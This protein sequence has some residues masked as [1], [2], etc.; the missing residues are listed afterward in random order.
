MRS[1]RSTINLVGLVS[2]AIWFFAT[3]FSSAIAQTTGPKTIE[4]LTSTCVACHGPDGNSVV[5]NWPKIAGQHESY[6]VVQLREFKKGESGH[7]YEPS[8]FG[9]V[10]GLSDEDMQQL[11]SYYSNKKQSSGT[12]D[13]K[14]LALGEKIYRGGNVETKVAACTSCHSP[15]GQG[16]SLA[17]FPKLAGQHTEYTKNQMIAFRDSK[18][19]TESGIMGAIAKK[20]TIQEIEAVSNY[21]EGLEP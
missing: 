21:I 9:M 18:R 3:Y 11:A 19:T 17:K 20:M 6:L 16:N 8:M 13:S 1:G 10:S 15:S 2:V 5:P 12:M 7:R 4:E 14:N